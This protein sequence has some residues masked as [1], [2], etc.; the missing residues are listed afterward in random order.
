MN[1]F[2]VNNQPTNIQ[3]VYL[4]V[5]NHGLFI[6]T[7]MLIIMLFDFSGHIYLKVIYIILFVFLPFTFT[8]NNKRVI[9][10]LCF[11]DSNQNLIIE[12]F[13][14]WKKKKKI[15]YSELHFES[16][17]KQ[18]SKNKNDD[19]MICFW[20]KKFIVGDIVYPSKTVIWDKVNIVDISQRLYLTKMNHQTYKLDE[21]FTIDGIGKVNSFKRVEF[22]N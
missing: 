3:I 16:I 18:N 4:Y 17:I 11:D 1:I 12:Y 22:F 2:C 14:L 20:R 13:V 10:K 8:R 9:Y 6:L 5:K 15:S 21:T 19:L 7:M